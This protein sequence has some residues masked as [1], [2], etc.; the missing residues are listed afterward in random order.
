[1]DYAI[2]RPIVIV[3]V[4][5]VVLPW[6]LLIMM[7]PKMIIIMMTSTIKMRIVCWRC[8]GLYVALGNR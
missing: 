1:M 8:L 2:S 5:V 4:F 7:M 3:V 6:L